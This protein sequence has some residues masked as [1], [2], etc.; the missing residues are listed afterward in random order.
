[1]PTV[2]SGSRV[3]W[4][5]CIE[6]G[7]GEIHATTPAFTPIR[8]NSS[9]LSRDTAQI[10]SEEI[11]DARQREKARQGTYS[12]AGTLVANVSYGSHD[13]LLAAAF[14]SSW[15]TKPTITAATISAAAADDS[16]ND[17]GSGFVAAGFKVGDYVT[18]TG[19]TGDVANNI[20]DGRI[21]ALTAGKMTIDAVKGAAIVD[22]AEG[23]SVTIA[24][25]GDYLDV[26]STVPTIALLRRNTDTGIDVLYRHC[27]MNGVDLAVTINRSA[28]F[29]FPVIGESVEKYTVP[30]GATFNAATTSEM[31]VPTIGYMHENRVALAY[32]T[33]YSLSVSN[34][35]NP[36]FVVFRRSAYSVE[37]GVFT[38][39]G[40]LSAFQE[41]SVL[42][43]KFID[44]T[45]SSHI[46]KLQD[47]DGN[48]YRFILP[49]VSYPQLSD[50]VGGPGAH[51]HSYTFSAGYEGVTTARIERGAA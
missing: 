46:V 21:I 39:S 12:I 13:A 15:V 51:I 34:A 23:E 43:D 1:M 38:A 35:M 33:D 10:E 25:A 20:T 9:D 24:V 29:S 45:A 14:Q 37:N 30:G 4:Y 16:F 11:N 28:T 3:K 18:V 50:P 44:E 7:S 19:F 17:S 5:Y 48:F 32:L 42:I 47:L 26:S 49:D 6:D 36:L 41:D 27:R 40:Q 31:M 2:A 8:F 22:D